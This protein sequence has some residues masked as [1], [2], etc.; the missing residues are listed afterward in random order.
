MST[1][2]LVHGSWHG[3]WCWERIVPL[4]EAGGHRVAAIDLPGHGVDT[5]PFFRI[6]LGSYARRI[7]EI[8]RELPEPPVLVGHSMGGTAITCAASRAPACYRALVYLC[9]F[10]PLPG[11]SVVWLAQEDAG[12]QVSA[13]I[14]R[15]P[16]SVRLRPGAAESLFYGECSPE[17]AA[18]AAARL[19]PDPVLPLFQKLGPGR[20][21]T[22]PRFYVA[23]ERDRALTIERQRAMASRAGI[24]CVVT[25]DT[26][27]SPFYSIPD[28]LAHRLLD[29]CG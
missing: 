15:R 27:H 2:L 5:T 11:D 8:A 20:P 13:S 22:A 1:F 6:A 10:V 26:D 21:I 23:C 16:L 19:R 17:D 29:L 28:E 4:L 25:L 9:A 18:G 12:S 3:A 14:R 24:E 7:E